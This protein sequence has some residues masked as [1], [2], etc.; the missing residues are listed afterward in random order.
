MEAQ[1]PNGVGF[2]RTESQLGLGAEGNGERGSNEFWGIGKEGPEG[3]GLIGHEKDL[4]DSLR[5][6][7][8]H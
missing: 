3:Q 7:R 4:G 1:R 5:T 8:S 2:Q 6:L